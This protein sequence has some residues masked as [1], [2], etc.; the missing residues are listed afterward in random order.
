MATGVLKDKY[1]RLGCLTN[2]IEQFVLDAGQ[3]TPFNAVVMY[4]QLRCRRRR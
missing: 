4:L 1:T 2:T 3:Q